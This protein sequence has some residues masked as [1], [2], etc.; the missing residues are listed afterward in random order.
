MEHWLKQIDQ[1]TVDF[2]ERFSHLS[3]TALNWKPTSDTWSIAQ[4]LD[5]LIVINES[6]FPVF[7]QLKTG[8]Y[9]IPWYGKIR[10][11]ANGMGKMILGAVGPDRRKK[12]KTFPIWEPASSTI[13]D[14]ILD[15]FVAH[16]QRLKEEFQACAKLLG[17]GQVI[18]SPANAS[19]VYPLE[20]AFAIIVNHEQRHL[21]QA[22]E[23]LALLPDLTYETN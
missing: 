4:N 6:Y 11:I 8:T 10:F 21:A 19:I 3:P 1:N 2:Q 18:S 14:D 9:Q 23:M 20:T 17:Q 15:R 22:E 12:T 5:H 7:E 13:S 16:Q